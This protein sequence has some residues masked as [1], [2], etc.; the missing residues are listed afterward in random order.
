MRNF[1]A[2]LF[3][4]LLGFL[5]A[6]NVF[7][8]N[9]VEMADQLRAD[10]KIYVVVGVFL[11]ISAGILTYLIFIDLRLKKLEKQ[12]SENQKELKK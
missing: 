6:G 5:S 9:S 10:G 4:I 11:L 1:L 12:R 7:G 2:G 3:V 8:Q